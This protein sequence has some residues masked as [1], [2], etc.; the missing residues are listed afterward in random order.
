LEEFAYLKKSIDRFKERQEQKTISLN[1]DERLARKKS[2]DDFQ[3]E[4]DAERDRL[5]K[6]NYVEHEVKLDSVVKAEAAGT[7]EAAATIDDGDTDATDGESKVKFDV[8]LRETLRVVADALHL[9]NN[10]LAWTEGRPPAA[11]IGLKKG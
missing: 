9:N 5:A 8:H 3:K 4:M 11:V 1:L 6:I 2:D 7:K 10:P